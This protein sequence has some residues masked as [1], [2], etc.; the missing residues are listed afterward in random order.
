MENEQVQKLPLTRFDKASRGFGRRK[1][2]WIIMK[3]FQETRPPKVNLRLH[4]A[5]IRQLN[6][7]VMLQVQNMLHLHI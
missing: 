3:N 7:S 5:E 1:T 2:S 6:A 4:H